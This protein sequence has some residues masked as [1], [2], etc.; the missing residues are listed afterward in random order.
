MS[1]TWQSLVRQPTFNTSTMLLLTDGRVMVQ[2]EGTQHWHALTADGSG[3]YINGTWSDLS[4]MSTWR[5]YYASGVLRDGRVIVCGGED[6]G[7][8]SDTTRCEIY[9]PT[10]DT[11]T[12]IASP[13]GWTMVG[14]ASSCV[15]PDG[16]FMIGALPS[17]ACAV[18]DPV[19]DAWA[20]AAAKAVRANEETWILL[21]DNTIISPQCFPPFKSE[22]YL[23]A[24]N[25]WQD[26]GSLPVT[27]VDPIMNEIGP[28][29]LLYTGSVIYFGAANSG[30]HGKTVLYRPPASPALQGTW[31]AGPDIPVVGGNTIVCN[32]CPASLLPN[33]KVLFAAAPFENDTW[34]SPIVFF[35]YDPI[36]NSI[37]QAPTPSNNNALL[38]LSRQMLLPT[39]QV[40]FSPSST[41][42][43]CYIPD[44]NPEDVWRPT[45]ASVQPTT[46]YLYEYVLVGTQLNG[47]SQANVYGDDCS[48]A[49][50]YPLVQL[51]QVVT[52]DVYFART[53]NFS[54]MAVATGTSTQSLR[55][56][57]PSIPDGQYDLRV[58]ANGIS[59]AKVDFYW[60]RPK[61]GFIDAV[62]KPDF[63]FLGKSI[64]EGDPWQ[65]WRQVIDPEIG[66]LQVQVREL[67]NS[68]QRLS[69]LIDVNSLPP[70]G[71]KVAQQAAEKEKARASK[72]S[73][74]KR[75]G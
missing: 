15:L 62:A 44:G 47:W 19:A 24:T 11:W 31:T 75:K 45:I 10:N 46:P 43:Q 51:R 74:A 57:L 41:N 53:H 6:S 72:P 8:G 17:G 59:S 30:G 4:D 36:A 2:E 9:D 42:I 49:T 3:S 67:Q 18:Y 54:T 21:P 33:G 71:K 26:E 39:G 7:L 68:V 22:K 60:S 63:D 48:P 69:S 16:R 14:D 52:G 27:L 56:D 55:F 64:Y 70:V 58:I 5:R 13:P 20:A 50:N 12:T 23:I 38:Y 37:T 34:G 32:D 28:A 29:M 73:G 61:P 65:R 1:G 66:D 25:S 40:L 35:E